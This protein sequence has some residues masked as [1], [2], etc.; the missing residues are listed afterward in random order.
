M[1]VLEEMPTGLGGRW[2]LVEYENNFYGYG[3][4]QDLHR[5][6]GF[7][8][9][10]CG[11]RDEVLAHCRSIKKLCTQNI[12]KYQKELEKEKRNP[13]GWELL[14][15]HEKKELEMLTKFESILSC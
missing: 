11:T 3:Y 4:E 7:P 9:N 6:S 13:N 15:G 5:L 12:E 14:I 2:V 8:V 10:Q 1:N